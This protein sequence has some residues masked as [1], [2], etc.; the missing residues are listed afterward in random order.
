Q[1]SSGE[2]TTLAT[3]GPGETLGEMSLLTGARRTGTAIV[4]EDIS[5]WVLH[6][7]SHELLRLD[8]GAGAVELAARLTEIVLARLR[9]RYAAIGAELAEGDPEPL[10]APPRDRPV[11]AA[12]NVAPAAY[13]RSLLCFRHFHDDEQIEAA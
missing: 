10:D 12:V 6:R 11:A 3:V 2:V 4:S 1:R 7:S 13:L 8:A 5:G 9:D